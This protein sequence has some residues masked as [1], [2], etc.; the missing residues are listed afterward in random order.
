MSRFKVGDIVRALPE[1]NGRY[2]ITN[3]TMGYIGQVV[4]ID[5]DEIFWV[6]SYDIK[7][8]TVKNAPRFCV[9]SRYFGL[10]ERPGA[11]KTINLLKRKMEQSSKG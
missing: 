11:S 10:V 6:R 8:H 9:A 7:T 2:K 4:E 5:S 1:T 3:E